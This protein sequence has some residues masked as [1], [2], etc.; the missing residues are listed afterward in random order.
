MGVSLSELA[1]EDIQRFLATEAVLLDERRFTEWL[2][3]WAPDACYWIPVDPDL[4]GG[5]DAVNHVYDDHARLR[6]RVA[7]LLGPAAHTEEPPPRSTRVHGPP[8]LKATG[9]LAHV[10]TPFVLT[11]HRQGATALVSGRYHHHLRTTD[12]GLRIVTKR[13][14]LID[15]DAP[16]NTLP[17]LL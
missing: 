3:L 16:L 6:T 7:R 11:A 15:A 17:T 1:G 13:V 10:V 14:D 8:V 12:D 2:D 5:D 9:E 4:A